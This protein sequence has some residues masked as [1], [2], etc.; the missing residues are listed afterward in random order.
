MNK[1]NTVA[2][3]QEE[4]FLNTFPLITRI[5]NKKLNGLCRDMV[6]DITQ[7][8]ALKLWI[9]KNNRAERELSE[10]EWQRLANTA[11]QNEIK[12]FHADEKHDKLNISELTDVRFCPLLEKLQTVK[13]AGNSRAEV[14]SLLSEIWNTIR[15]QSLREK[16]A[17]LLKTDEIINHLIVY[18]CV[19]RE[20]IA[21]ILEL[22]K[23]ELDELLSRESLSDAAIAEVLAAKLNT[24][25]TAKHVLEA[26]HRAK[27]KIKNALA[28]IKSKDNIIER[29]DSRRRTL[30]A[31]K[32]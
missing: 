21:D 15:N 17:L 5:A 3:D 24:E 28:E 30:A 25:I 11:A 6:E 20:E 9:W 7:K 4:Y 16:Y 26:R 27:T 1:E 29:P 31:G 13:T 8:V 12:R 22:S 14:R 2:A 32:T 23:P 19:R 18:R 10:E